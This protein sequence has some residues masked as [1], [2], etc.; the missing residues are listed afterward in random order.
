MEEKKRELINFIESIS[1]SE[2]LDYIHQFIE[3][4][5]EW[6]PSGASRQ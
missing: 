2:L 6:L 3:R 5:K 1:D 4:M